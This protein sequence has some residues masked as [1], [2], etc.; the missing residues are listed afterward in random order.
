MTSALVQIGQSDTPGYRDPD[1][2]ANKTYVYAVRTVINTADGKTLESANSNLATVTLHDAFPPS[3]PTQ[4]IVT[5]VP[6]V[7][8]VAAH[9]DLSWAINPETDLAGYDVYRSE[10]AGTQGTKITSQPLPT[11]AFTDMNAVPGR[12]YYY[13]VTAVDRTGNESA[14]SAVVKATLTNGNV[15]AL[16]PLPTEGQAP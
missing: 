16:P 2:Q 3:V 5:A 7:Q 14:A 10:Q 15:P 11:P 9:I 12:T 13:S 4:L 8:S 1:G 6:G